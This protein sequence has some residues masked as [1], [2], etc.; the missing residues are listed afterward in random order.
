ML[1][2]F[3]VKAG[4]L[5]SSTNKKAAG[6]FTCGSCLFL[7]IGGSADHRR[8]SAIVKIKAIIRCA[9]DCRLLHDTLAFVIISQT[10]SIGGQ[11]MQTPK[12]GRQYGGLFFV[13]SFSGSMLP[14]G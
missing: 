4:F 3:P 11:K 1:G 13:V 6:D 5:I 9:G 8:T 2:P 14:T 7:A 10:C 12:K